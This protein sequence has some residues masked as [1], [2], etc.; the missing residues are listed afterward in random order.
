MY[1]RSSMERLGLEWFSTLHRLC[2]A[3]AAQTN[4]RMGDGRERIVCRLWQLQ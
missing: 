1:S 4:G 3:L 2:F